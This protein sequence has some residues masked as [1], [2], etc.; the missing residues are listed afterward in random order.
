MGPHAHL[1]PTCAI[2]ATCGEWV[3]VYEDIPIYRL[4]LE[5]WRARGAPPVIAADP[6]WLI[7]DHISY[8]NSSASP[9]RS[10]IQLNA[11]VY[12]HGSIW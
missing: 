7:V 6:Q 12:D 10:L 5:S 3:R 8:S 11:V 9:T 2:C 1:I 4:E